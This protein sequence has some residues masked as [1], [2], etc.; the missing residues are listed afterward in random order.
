M[1]F[2]N[3]IFIVGHVIS[4]FYNY[5]KEVQ[6]LQLLQLLQMQTVAERADSAAVLGTLGLHNRF[7]APSPGSKQP[8]I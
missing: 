3:K 7:G 2:Q 8:N 5:C 6:L 1:Y 4:V